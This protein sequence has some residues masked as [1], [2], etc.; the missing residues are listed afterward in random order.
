MGTRVGL[1]VNP[2]A[3]R[4]GGGADALA[5][6][7]LLRAR[8]HAVV[9]LSAPTPGAALQRA[10][11]AVGA[12]SVDALVVAG[13][14]GMVHLGVNVCAGDGCYRSGSWR[15]APATTSPAS[16]ACR[17]VTPPSPSSASSPGHTR[18]V[19]AARHVMPTG[20]GGGSSGVLAAG[21]DAVVNDRAN[22]WR[23]PRGAMR[24]NLAV[25]RE[26]PVFRAIPYVL[27]PRRG[28]PR[29][30][31]HARRRGQRAGVRRR[32]AGDARRGVRRR[33]PRRPRPPA[34]PAARVPP[35]L[36]PGV[37][38]DATSSH[39][40]VEVLRARRV[41]LEATGIVSYADGERFAP[42]PVDLEAV[43]GALTV[44]A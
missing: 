43:P 28:A 33:P 38:R 17:C 37:Q 18:S 9:P 5:L 44:L 11:D 2:A 22:Q 34:D 36:P 12:G 16:S 10:R 35:R 15:P 23:W 1:V 27:D 7:A 26:L 42:L 20:D 39:P 13:G 24:Y 40:A 31:G 32:D 41:S 21:F 3:G 14:D 8:G 30:R 4:P 29:D 19:D 6:T 25:A